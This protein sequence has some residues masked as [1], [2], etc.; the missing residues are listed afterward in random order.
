LDSISERT[1]QVWWAYYQCEPFGSHW[2]QAASVMSVVH[3]NSAMLAATR[4]AKMEPLSVLDFMP[5]DSMKW[6]K[7]KKLKSSGIKH[8]K[9]QAE[10]LKKA[11]GFS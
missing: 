8:P 2:E 5:S 10:I 7:R 11:F 9:I 1:F 6:Q 4:G 3:A